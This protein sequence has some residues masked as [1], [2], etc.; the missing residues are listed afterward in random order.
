MPD[1]SCACWL[2]CAI[3]SVM[4]RPARAARSIVVGDWIADERHHAVA[5]VLGDIA[6]KPLDG[7]RCHSMVT[8][9][10]L[11]P[12]LGV[13]PRA[14]SVEPTRSQNNTVRCR[15]SPL[16]GVRGGAAASTFLPAASSKA[17]PHSPQNLNGGTFSLPHCGQ[18][19]RN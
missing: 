16:A 4:A 3:L 5:Q 6:T 19:S 8:G 2:S 10:E 14:I 9:D 11:P 1:T 15:R 7:L 13:E 17:A 18:R 12:L